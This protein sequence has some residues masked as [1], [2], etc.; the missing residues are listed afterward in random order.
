MPPQKWRANIQPPQIIVNASQTETQAAVR[1]LNSLM[2][3]EKL[4]LVNV[5]LKRTIKS[6]R[7]KLAKARLSFGRIMAETREMPEWSAESDVNA[8]SDDELTRLVRAG[9]VKMQ[10][11]NLNNGGNK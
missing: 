7:K 5:G 6:L 4:L 1:E 11:A 10:S 3:P 9:F 2:D 8:F